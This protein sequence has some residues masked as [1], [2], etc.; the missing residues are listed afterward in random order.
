M[1]TDELRQPLRRKPGQFLRMFIV[2]RKQRVRQRC[3]L[4][5]F[6]R[7]YRQ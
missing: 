3:R 4:R 5:Y 7:C 1:F 2:E 6:S